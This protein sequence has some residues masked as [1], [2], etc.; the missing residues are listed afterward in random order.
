MVKTI[1][2]YLIIGQ[3]KVMIAVTVNTRT[4]LQYKLSIRMTILCLRVNGVILVG[5][6]TVITLAM[7]E[8][9]AEEDEAWEIA[10]LI[11][12]QMKIIPLTS[13]GEVTSIE[14]GGVVESHGEV[15]GPEV[16]VGAATLAAEV[17][18]V[19]VAKRS[20][21]LNMLYSLRQVVIWSVT[22]AGIRIM[23]LC[24]AQLVSIS[25]QW[26]EGRQI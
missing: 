8:D 14:A 16:I 2:L 5:S 23:V 4:I 11:G 12:I 1:V 3:M 15:H 6:V 19:G 22:A 21:V 26:W 17:E 24:I 25:S 9:E 13:V 18:G 10:L 7:V 20:L